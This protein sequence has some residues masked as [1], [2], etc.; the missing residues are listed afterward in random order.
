MWYEYSLFVVF[1][2]VVGKSISV[3]VNKIAALKQRNQED[4]SELGETVSGI[5]MRDRSLM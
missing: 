4:K 3:K 2:V 5:R 1:F